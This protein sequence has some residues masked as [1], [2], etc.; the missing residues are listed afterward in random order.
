MGGMA[1]MPPGM[2]GAAGARAGGDRG[3]QA[4]LNEDDDFWGAPEG[5]PPSI[6][7]GQ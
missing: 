6:I 1:M 5:L 7:G 2:G 3:R 4:W